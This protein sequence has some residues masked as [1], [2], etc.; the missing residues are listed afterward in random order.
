MKSILLLLPK[1]MILI[2]TLALPVY[3]ESEIIEDILDDIIEEVRSLSEEKNCEI[4]LLIID[5][6]SND[7]TPLILQRKTKQYVK[8]KIVTH[9][10]NQGYRAAIQSCLENSKGDYIIVMDSDGQY[11]IS[12][13]PKFIEKCKEGYNL[14]LG[15]KMKRSD[16]KIRIWLG[17]GYNWLFRLLFSYNVKEVDCGF[18]AL[19]QDLAKKISLGV[20]NLP[21]G[22]EILVTAIMNNCKITDVPVI[23]KPRKGGETVFPMSKLPSV[24]SYSFLELIKLRMRSNKIK[25][26]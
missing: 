13:L 25:S 16:P 1:K 14:V 10:T 11:S 5:D 21:I 26:S 20:G 4:E 3:N 6:G 22:P 18:R 23:H 7:D 19:S 17:K 8:M 2:F 15:T 24:I 12:D 9:K